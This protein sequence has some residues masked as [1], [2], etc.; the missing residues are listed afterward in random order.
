MVA[1]LSCLLHYFVTP[2]L[3]FYHFFLVNVVGKIHAVVCCGSMV[4]IGGWAVVV[5]IERQWSRA[6]SGVGVSGV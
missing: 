5:G 3:Q 4:W 6:G 1:W 2:G